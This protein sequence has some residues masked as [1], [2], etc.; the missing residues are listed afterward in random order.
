MK[1]LLVTTEVDEK[2]ING[3]RLPLE[4]MKADVEIFPAKSPDSTE[5][6]IK[7]AFSSFFNL[8]D[9]EEKE[10]ESAALTHILIISPVAQRYL[11]F[12]A[13]FSYGASLPLLVYGEDAIAGI[14]VELAS[15]FRPLNTETSLK[16]YFEAEREAYEKWAAAS[17]IIRARDTLLQMGIPVTGESFADC[18]GEGNVLEVSLFLTAGFSPDTRNKNGIPLLNIA[19]RKGN[20][21][22]LGHLIQAGAQFNLQS[23]DRGTSALLD[24][25][26]ANQHDILEDL[27]NAGAD[28]NIKSKSGQTALVVAVGAGDER[29]VEALL[30]A[31]ADP[32]ITD[33]MGVSARKYAGLFRKT[34]VTTLFDTYAPIKV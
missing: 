6:D 23:D 14:P 31:G 24:S 21:A 22:I 2:I 17:E 9:P 1:I 13:G 30:K 28:L 20:R 4:K 25:A 5:V 3:L 15:F 27:I 12:L 33:N 32:D 7:K 16:D 18:A 11:D 26:M 34:S 10:Q 19:A 8:A 29:M